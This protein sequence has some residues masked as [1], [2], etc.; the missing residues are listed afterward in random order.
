MSGQ[1]ESRHFFRVGDR[2]RSVDGRAGTVVE[3]WALF[4]TI[5]WA[6]GPRDEVEQFDE[7]VVVELR[8]E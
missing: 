5:E 7:S 2:V 8:W 1:L 4:A 3:A 6:D